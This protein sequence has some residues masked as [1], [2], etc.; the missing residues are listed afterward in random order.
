MARRLLEGAAMSRSHLRTAAVLVLGALTVTAATAAPAVAGTG[1]RKPATRKKAI[2]ADK[3]APVDTFALPASHPH[4]ADTGAAFDLSRPSRQASIPAGDG[5]PVVEL[6]G[7]SAGQVGDTVRARLADVDYCWLR[8]PR[9]KRAA[10]TAVLRFSIDAAGTVTT[11][12]VDGVPADAR[13]CIAAAAATWTFPA[14]DVGTEA[15][16]AID[17]H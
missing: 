7:L 14:A 8:V 16:Y 9:G 17:L 10:T 11:A 15:D 1:K 13:A 6:R 4:R 5:A 2:T 3:P 12:G